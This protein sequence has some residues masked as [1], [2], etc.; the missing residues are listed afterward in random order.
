MPKRPRT[1]NQLANDQR[2]RD[3][4]KA[5]RS[6]NVQEPTKPR[7]EKEESVL[8]P[9]AQPDTKSEEPTI[10]QLLAMI[11]EL[12]NSPRA[13]APN[14]VQNAQITP[15]GIVGTVEKHS[16]DVGLYPDPAPRLYKEQRLTPFAFQYNYDIGWGIDIASYETKDGY[17]MKEPKFT[18]QLNRIVLDDDGNQTDKRW[19][20]KRMIFFEDPQTALT[21]ARDNGIQVDEENDISFLNEMRYLRIRD[22]LLEIFYP[23]PSETLRQKK[24][25]VIGGTIVE[26]FEA[27]SE[28][29]EKIPFD[30]MKTPKL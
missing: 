6:Q 11:E 7:E 15:R 8:E 22:W 14:P 21:V 18:I 5:R 26:V 28:N 9:Q 27:K 1:A 20:V 19:V 13:T 23:K 12:K 25:E 10:Q 17:N 2:L 29:P 24:Q 3:Q 4:A 16:V 30:Q